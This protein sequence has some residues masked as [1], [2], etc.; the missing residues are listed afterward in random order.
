MDEQV[1][2]AQRRTALPSKS[3][4]GKSLYRAEPLCLLG[5]SVF[6]ADAFFEIAPRPGEETVFRIRI[7]RRVGDVRESASRC[8]NGEIRCGNVRLCAAMCG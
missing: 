6:M 5:L 3:Y 7:S 4:I 1:T 2:L 8:G